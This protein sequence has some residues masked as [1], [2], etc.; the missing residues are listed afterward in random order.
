M[1][2]PSPV[3]YAPAERLFRLARH[4]AGT[5]TGLTLDEMAAALEDDGKDS[6]H[7]FTQAWP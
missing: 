5:R 2:Q 1:K 6:V 4:L 3:R 7:A